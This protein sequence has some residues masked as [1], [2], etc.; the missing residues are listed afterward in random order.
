MH[1]S[2]DDVHV[3]V[4]INVRVI[5]MHKAISP[6]TK[7]KEILKYTYYLADTEQICNCLSSLSIAHY[8]TG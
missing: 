1:L 6:F 8:S 4:Y 3:V 7:N 5:I 2:T